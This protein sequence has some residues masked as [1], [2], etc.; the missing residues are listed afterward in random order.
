MFQVHT[1]VNVIMGFSEILQMKMNKLAQEKRHIYIRNIF[2]S[3]KKTYQLLESLLSWARS[4]SERQK[5]EPKEIKINQL[6]ME[7]ILL[8]REQSSKKNITVNFENH[9]D[10]GIVF[11][12]NRMVETVLRNLISNAIKF[13]AP[14]GDITVSCSTKQ[15]PGYSTIHVTDTGVGISA[16]QIPKLFHIEK[17][18]STVGTNG[19]TGTGLGLVLCKEF[20]E[21]NQGKIWVESKIG[22]GTAFSFTLPL[23]SAL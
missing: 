9:N 16:E 13:T 23:A 15:N 4:Q 8:L 12:D 17:S 5:H 19:E 7:S 1:P 20:I 2:E 14:G 6:I 21:K 11:C 18:F 3:A 10:E 22:K